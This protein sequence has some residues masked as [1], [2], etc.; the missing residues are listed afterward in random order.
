LFSGDG[1]SLALASSLLEVD[2]L[3]KLVDVESESFGVIGIESDFFNEWQFMW[4]EVETTY[5]RVVVE[6]YAE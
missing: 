4:I 1:D 2:E 5:G 3:L 6:V